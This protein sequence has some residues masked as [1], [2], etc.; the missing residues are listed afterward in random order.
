VV[1]KFLRRKFAGVQQPLGRWILR[2]VAEF[3]VLSPAILV[4]WLWLKLR[5]KEVL[6]VGRISNT[7]SQFIAPLE[8]ELRRRIQSQGLIK[9][10]I[11]LNLS[12]DANEQIRKMYDRIVKI[13]GSESLFMRRLIWWASQKGV[14]RQV[15]FE[16]KS[17]LMW[18]TGKPTVSFTEREEIEGEIFLQE[19][20]LEKNNYLCFTV[21]SESYYLAR[22]NEGQNISLNT[23]RNPDEATY[24]KVAVL[25]GGDGFTVVRMGKDLSR[26]E[27]STDDSNILDYAG[28]FRSDFLDC[29][30]MRYC[31]FS[32]VGNT[33]IVWLRWLWNLPNVHGDSY[34]VR[35][36]QIAGDLYLLQKVWM[37][38][39]N[40]FATF[41][42]MLKMNHY[43]VESRMKG[44]GVCLIKNTVEEIKAVCDEMNARIDGTCVTTEE[45]EELQRRYQEL[46]VK[47]SNKPEWNGGGRIGAQFLREN[48]D[49][50]RE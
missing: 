10:T 48:Q 1:P 16:N 26:S 40:R 30:L 36:N 37:T 19:H 7:I 11:V 38:N 32:F 12:T 31:K 8:P 28:C 46:I 22:I 14:N 49:L 44:L 42:E 5:H 17:D 43:S 39:E 9:R 23:V 25:M 47:Y 29:Y 24:Q 34:S 35:H 13:Y 3:I 27:Y 45:D 21:R 4:T 6:I 15:L 41:V 20:G 33:G 18:K 50:L 2:H